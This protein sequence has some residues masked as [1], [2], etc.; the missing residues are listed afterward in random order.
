MSRGGVGGRFG[1]DI[2]ALHSGMI[3]IT[4]G[5]SDPPGDDRVD[6]LEIIGDTHLLRPAD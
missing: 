2:L 6:P 3:E 1:A 4:C 5:C